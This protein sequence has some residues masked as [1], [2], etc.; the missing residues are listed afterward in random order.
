[1]STEGSNVL[2]LHAS[3]GVQKQI[4]DRSARKMKVHR[5]RWPFHPPPGAPEFFVVSTVKKKRR[6]KQSHGAARH[7]STP[8]A[9]GALLG[10]GEGSRGRSVAAPRRS[11]GERGGIARRNC[12]RITVFSCLVP[13]ARVAS[14]GSPGWLITCLVRWTRMSCIAR[15][16]VG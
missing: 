13:H 6:R 1:M 9:R 4:H 14:I 7:A 16:R 12:L 2:E 3:A 8:P 5:N 15:A 10:F 11:R